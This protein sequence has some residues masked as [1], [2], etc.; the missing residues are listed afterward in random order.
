MNEI[1]KVEPGALSS[2]QS[3][4]PVITEGPG[5]LLSAIVQLARDPAVDVAKLD[6]LLGMQERMEARQAEREFAQAFARL[7][8]A[9]PRVKKNGAIDLGGGRKS[10]PFARWEDMDTIIRPLLEREGFALSFDAAPRPGEGG[11]LIVTGTLMHRDGHRRTASM[12]LALDIGPAR[13]SLQAMGSTLSYGKRYTTEML[14]NIV[15]EGDD[16]DGTTGGAGRINEAT[17]LE[18]EELIRATKS[19]RSRFMQ[20][21]GLESMLEM[22]RE[23]E[24]HARKALNARRAQQ[25][26]GS[27]LPGDRP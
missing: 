1:A 15:R 5:A 16:D 4:P 22:T 13:N 19:D 23:Q 14:L 8:G 10:I 7:S 27:D 18:I 25:A 9:L 17:A 6:A 3:G 21:F 11:G 24:Q 2:N 26:V 20:H 12:P